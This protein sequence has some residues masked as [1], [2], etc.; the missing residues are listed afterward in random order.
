MKRIKQK[1]DF[2]QEVVLKTDPEHK[3]RL[4]SGLIINPHYQ[5]LYELSFDEKQAGIMILKLMD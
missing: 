2:G 4:V 5:I 1:F 3:K